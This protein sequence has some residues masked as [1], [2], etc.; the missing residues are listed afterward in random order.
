MKL[1]DLKDYSRMQQDHGCI[2]PPSS[3]RIT[4]YENRLF[5]AL[6][7]QWPPTVTQHSFVT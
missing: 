5:R 1:R 6:E 3:N 2:H 4:L 7:G